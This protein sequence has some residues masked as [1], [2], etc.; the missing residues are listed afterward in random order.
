MF[1][2]KDDIMK[3][4]DDWSI[5]KYGNSL[6]DEVEQYINQLTEQSKHTKKNKGTSI[7]RSSIEAIVEEA[8]LLGIRHSIKG[9]NKKAEEVSKRLVDNFVNKST[10]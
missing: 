2:R 7:T 1:E 10:K 3:Q 6:A 9:I 4:L 8:Y 5:Y